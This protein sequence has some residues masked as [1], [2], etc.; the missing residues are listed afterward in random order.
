M[1][2][3]QIVESPKSDTNFIHY[4]CK[5]THSYLQDNNV[6]KSYICHTPV[7]VVYHGGVVNVCSHFQQAEDGKSSVVAPVFEVVAVFPY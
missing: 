3:L 1:D 6:F 2:F 7:D 5:E 4:K